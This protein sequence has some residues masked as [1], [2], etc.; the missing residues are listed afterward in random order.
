[1]TAP[2]STTARSRPV[3]VPLPDSPGASAL[4]GAAAALCGLVA[5]AAVAWLALWLLGADSVGSLGTMAMALAAMAVGGS[6]SAGSVNSGGSAGGSGS[7]G[8]MLSGLLGGGGGGMSPSMSGA[9]DV[10]PL[11]VTLVGSVVLWLVFSRRLRQR[12]VTARE[13]GARAAG[14]GAAALT[15]FV[16]VATLAHGTFSLPASAMSRG[17]GGGAQGAGASGAGSGAMGALGGMFGG[18]GSSG[19]SASAQDTTMSYEVHVGATAFGALV[20]VAVVLALGCLVSRRVRVPLGGAVDRV[21]PGWAPG[22]SAVVRTLLVLVVVPMALVTFVGVVAGGRVGTVA[23]WVLLLAPNALAVLLT[24]G[25]GA[26][27]TAATHPVQSQGGNPL[28]SLMGALGGGQQT[29]TA[30]PDRTEHLRSLAAGGRPLWLGALVVTAVILLVCA[31]AAARN[32]A[33][34]DARP[35]HRYDGPLARHLGTAERFGVVTAVVLGSAAW[36]AGAS[37]HIGVSMFGSEMGGTR[38]E[39][40]G[41]VLWTVVFG[42]LAGGVAGFL[43]SLLRTADL[44]GGMTS[45]RRILARKS[46]SAASSHAPAPGTDPGTLEAPL[47]NR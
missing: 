28:A 15:A 7:A 1:M 29:S 8:S 24:L 19:G 43:G 20:W 41:S 34:A 31:R 23:G 36:P 45:S 40:S 33:P 26:P 32:T 2:A 25:V 4:E 22:L 47:G 30:Q 21:R 9:V 39:L 18:S 6:V 27:W 16:L 13:L 35:L 5:M 17:L 37:G 46:P 38:A 14:A 11:G 42:L 3:S 44:Y 10:A 12:P